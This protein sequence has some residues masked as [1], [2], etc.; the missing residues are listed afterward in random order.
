[1]ALKIVLQ[2]NCLIERNGSNNNGNHV[3]NVIQWCGDEGYVA[4]MTT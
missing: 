4:L 1:M 2:L 3:I